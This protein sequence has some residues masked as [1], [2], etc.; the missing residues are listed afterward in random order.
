MTECIYDQVL[1]EDW[2][3]TRVAKFGSGGVGMAIVKSNGVRLS[4]L[5]LFETS[6][7]GIRSLGMGRTAMEELNFEPKILL[8]FDDHRSISILIRQLIDLKCWMEKT[9]V[10]L[11]E[12][13]TK[14]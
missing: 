9:N 1:R 14:L 7:E 10:A 11:T 3:E 12:G 5:A 13:E 6:A 4:G 8:H 2:K